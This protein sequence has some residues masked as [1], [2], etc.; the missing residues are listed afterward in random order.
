MN[1]TPINIIEEEEW[2][3]DSSYE[4][5]LFTRRRSNWKDIMKRQDIMKRRDIMKKQD[6]KKEKCEECA[7]CY[8]SFTSSIPC[9]T[10]PCGHKFH[11]SCL[12]QNFEHR[13]ECP[14]CRTELIKQKEEENDDDSSYYS[15]EEQFKQIVSIKQ[16]ADKLQTLGYTIEDV[17]MLHFGG[18]SHPKDIENPRW[19]PDLVDDSDDDNTDTSSTNNHSILI[20]INIDINNILE[21]NLAV[22]Y[23]D[24]RTY[25][26]VLSSSSIINQ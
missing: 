7:I 10:T 3:D 12:F 25:A 13:P 4:S 20:K 8:E 6:I 2:S 11:S 15:E 22:K 1:T 23:T 17:L 9:S 24:T 5:N 14:L 16:M 21:G 18:S 26:Q 19:K